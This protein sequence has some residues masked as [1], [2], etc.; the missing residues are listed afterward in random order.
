MQ[1]E[2]NHTVKSLF[3]R[4]NLDELPREDLHLMTIKYP[5]SSI[6]QFLYTRKLQSQKD[7][8]YAG[9]VAKTALYFSNPHWLHHQLRVKSKVENLAE[10]ERVYRESHTQPVEIIQETEKSVIEKP[11]EVLIEQAIDSVPAEEETSLLSA[12]MVEADALNIGEKTDDELTDLAATEIV[13]PENLPEISSYP[14]AETEEE[15]VFESAQPNIPEADT[16]IPE[17]LPEI[18]V[19]DDLIETEQANDKNTETI[20]SPEIQLV[21]INPTVEQPSIEESEISQAIIPEIQV[22]SETA[23]ANLP[24]ETTEIPFEPLYAVDYFASQGIRLREEDQQDQLGKKLKSFTEWLKSMKKIHPE[25]SRDLFDAK[26]EA[27]IK[28]EADQSNDKA[29]VLT[30]TM[31]EVLIKQGLIQKA[32]EVYEK[33]SLLD[34]PKSAT[35]AAKISELKAIGT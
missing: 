20:I 24:S 4:E 10:K 9:S 35:F 21:E 27:S 19:N 18:P 17:D 3:D 25:K 16:L 1:T 14:S 32:I 26:T 22:V 23:P 34:P 5:Y 33:L 29:D 7:H 11:E 31:A 28:S 15:I 12:G 30:E 8:G 2:L 6:L 13:N